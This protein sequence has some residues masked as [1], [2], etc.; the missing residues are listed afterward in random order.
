MCY[1]IVPSH[2]IYKVGV[3][4]IIPV[5][6]WRLSQGQRRRAPELKT[7]H[8][9]LGHN[10][11]VHGVPSK[12][13]WLLVSSAACLTSTLL[14]VFPWWMQAKFTEVSVTGHLLWS[15][16]CDQLAMGPLA[17]CFF[18][19][20]FLSSPLGIDGFLRSLKIWQLRIWSS[21]WVPISL[22]F[23]WPQDAMRSYHP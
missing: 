4:M 19:P 14:C 15:H 21:A 9:A 20:G 12:T 17:T 18:F 13:E 8:L 7:M 16:L 22:A 3:I 2:Q 23:P 6:Q 11:K 5:S 1:F 10:R